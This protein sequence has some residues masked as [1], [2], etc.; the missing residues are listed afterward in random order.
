MKSII[1]LL[2]IGSI[3]VIWYESL[4]VRERVLIH[5]RD[6]CE[7][8]GLQFLDQTVALVSLSLRRTPAGNPTVFRVYQFEV[9]EHG[10]DRQRGYIAVTGAKIHEVRLVGKEGNTILYHADIQRVH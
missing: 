2:L 8:A 5:C 4:R 3:A 9:S 1:L 6:I 7:R 10:T